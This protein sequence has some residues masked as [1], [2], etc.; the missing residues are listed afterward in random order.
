MERFRLKEIKKLS[1]KIILLTGLHIGAGSDEIKIGGVDTPVIKDKNGI[2]YIPGSS[3][4]GKVRTLLEWYTGNVDL[5]KGNPYSTS[6]S[7]NP[8]A[9]IFGNGSN[10][11]NYSGGPTRASFSDCPLENKEELLKVGALT[12]VKTEV[13]INRI[14]GTVSSAGPRQ[15]ERV[16]AGAEFKF[17]ITYR[18]FDMGDNGDTDEKNFDTLLKGLKLLEYDSLGG[19]GSRGYGRVKFVFDDEEIKKK[20]DNIK[21]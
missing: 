13:S 7:N 9:R 11:E 10:N 15:M 3:L 20:F 4:K 19:S 8:I 12:E 17:L 5:E 18:V 16:P 1:G 2:P 14:S 6:D 21:I